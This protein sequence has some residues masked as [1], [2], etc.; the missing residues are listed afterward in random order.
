MT[1][2]LSFL[3]DGD[4]F[5]EIFRDGVNAAKAARDYEHVTEVVP[6]SRRID[7]SLAPGG[8][9]VAKITRKPRV[10]SKATIR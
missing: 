9:W 8:G 3:G 6:F 1:L 7:V 10:I 5:M 4:W 2:D